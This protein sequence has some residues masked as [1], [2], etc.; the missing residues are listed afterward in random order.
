MNAFNAYLCEQLESMLAKRRVV[1]F[2][3][4]R[5]EFEPFFDRELRET[6]AGPGSLVNVFIGE[7][8]TLLARYR[9]SALR[10]RSEVEPVVARDEP[11]ALLIYL[12]GMKRDRHGSLLMELEKAGWTYEPQL[13]KLAR[14]VLRRFFT[15]GAIDDMLAPGSLTY[16]DVVG[17]LEQ[18]EDGG[19]ASILKTIFGA[20]TSENL[21]VRWLTD[22]SSDE[23]VQEK[24]ADA[25]LYRLIE[26]R[27]GLGLSAEIAISDARNRT[28]RY[29]L[30]NEFRSDLAGDPPSSMAMVPVPPSKDHEVRI[31]EITST[32]RRAH[33]DEYAA[34]ADRVEA[35][36]A[37]GQAEVDAGSLGSTDTFR[38]EER[39]LLARAIDL[40]VVREYDAALEIVAGRAE[41]FWIDR[42]LS[43][44]AEWEACRLSAELGRETTRVARELGSRRSE[45][46]GWVTTYTGEERW[47]EVDRLQR[48][49]ESWISQ[50]D[51]DP[52][53][54]R[55]IAV[56]RQAHD[57]LL[58][59]MADGFSAALAAAGWTVA[60]A[61]HQTQI[62]PELVQ[63]GGARVAYFW[64]D[65]LRYEMGAELADQLPGVEELTLRP[66]IGALPTITPVGMAAL[67]PGAAA[68]FS[69]GESK[70]KL[71]PK[72]EGTVVPDL[73][74]RLRFLKARVPDVVDLT[75]AKVLHTPAKRLSSAIGAASLVLV[76][77]QEIDFGGEIDNDFVAR[78]VMETS[79]ANI[80]RA[81]RKLATAGV[82]SFVITSD[83]GHQ[84]SLRREEDMRTDSP[85]GDTVGL[86]RRCWAGRGGT[87]PPGAVRVSGAELGYDTDLDFVFPT[88]LGVFKA[89]GGLTYHHGG[90]S[91]QEMVIPVLS[92]RIPKVVESE[93]AGRVVQLLDVPEALTNR[94]FGVRLSLL[95]DLL[96]TD[97]VQLR[98]ALVAGDQQVGQ[99]GMAVGAEIDRSS[100]VVTMEPG[101][102][103]SLG[104]MLTVENCDRVRLVVQD[105]A[106][107]AVLAQSPEIPVRLG[108]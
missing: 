61:L 62:Y 79:I 74:A 96:T 34:L 33:D 40:A 7:R 106:T 65:A 54:E 80:A 85:G 69:V 64:V 84:F 76:R 27:I 52:E 91:L 67:L 26:A 20:A 105:P 8:L 90:I 57:E 46:H 36:L 83:H 1:L 12:P 18:A 70:G 35:D 38:F 66:A 108:I 68:S 53:A 55:A 23:A 72:V 37:L 3:D 73:P 17:Y 59:R 22:K 82:E 19:E 42:D 39:R 71:S 32:L 15:D 2:Y 92:F 77:S 86:H 45:A 87:T 30:V 24:G 51:D 100:G 102:E 101:A 56:V 48:R 13:R 31:F 88:G 89:G 9:G 58:K 21:L 29:L 63:P 6:G 97:P 94:T 107:D 10:L 47:F 104:I 4:P 16:S 49:L 78:Q 44:Q 95:G 98:V 103:A 11:D 81:V 41:S 99:A 25:E 5:A 93:P 28:S 14:N 60:N 50:M 75:L 43:R